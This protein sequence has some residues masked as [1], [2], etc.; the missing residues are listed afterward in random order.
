VQRSRPKTHVVCIFRIIFS[1]CI[2]DL[3][4]PHLSGGRKPARDNLEW[5]CSVIEKAKEYWRRFKESEAGHRFQDRYRRHQENRR[6]RFDARMFLSIGG[7]ILVVVGGL[8]AVPGPGPGWV[9]I[10]LGLGLIAGEFL[11]VARFLDRAEVKLRAAAQWAV[12]A[13]TSS[14]IAVKFRYVWRSCSVSSRWGTERITCSSGVRTSSR[15]CDKPR[16]RYHTLRHRLLLQQS[17]DKRQGTAA[18]TSLH[19]TLHS[20]NAGGAGAFP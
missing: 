2:R 18:G 14:S 20:L 15:N 16:H 9:I 12:N 5:V 8:I 11:P 7:G 1:P 19:D 4:H 6:S 3:T 10:F 13:W 17:P